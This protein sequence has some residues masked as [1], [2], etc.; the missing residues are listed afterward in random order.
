M[1]SNVRTLR[2]ARPWALWALAISLSACSPGT[3]AV[4]GPPPAMHY[5]VQTE[6]PPVPSDP[7]TGSLW[8]VDAP[9]NDLFVNPKARQVG[10]IVT[11][12]IV[13]SASA[14]NKAK[15]NTGRSS[16]LAAGLESFFNAEK[17]FPSDQPFFNPFSQI[18]G[19]M[20]STFDG[21][22][23]T[24]RSGDLNAYITARVSRMHFN[25]NLEI[26]GSRE[27]TVNNEKQLISLSGI[28]RP[29]DISPDNVVLST[30]I[31]DAKITYSGT[32][33]IDDRQKPGWLVRIVDKIWPF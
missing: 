31:S 32:G 30:Y 24:S 17:R 3:Q 26:I 8:Q 14:S 21:Q 27:V 1:F 12:R 22:G 13:E 11:I 6:A 5:H 29:R 20:S 19:N 28:I 18:K 9:L 4:N 33:V 15:T 10:D 23:T 7:R 2:G 16:S 25:G